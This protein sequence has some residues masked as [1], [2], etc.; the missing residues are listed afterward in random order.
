MQISKKR[1][2]A[3]ALVVGAFATV[4]CQTPE[5]AFPGY[6]NSVRA[7]A[8]VAALD[9]QGPDGG[10]IYDFARAHSQEMCQA[11]YIFHSDLSKYPGSWG[12]LDENVGVNL[13][14][15]N[16]SANWT[17]RLAAVPRAG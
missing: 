13:F 16:D 3:A 8:G 4:G 7:A 14:P 11:G 9:G 2:L 15:A 5:A 6:A 12:R 1:G 17:P 10:R